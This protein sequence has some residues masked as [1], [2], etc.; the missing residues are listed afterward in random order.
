MVLANKTKTTRLKRTGIQAEILLL[1]FLSRFLSVLT[2]F[3]LNNIFNKDITKLYITTIS[4]TG[5]FDKQ[6]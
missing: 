1:V 5:F 4:E 6:R 3:A 2:Q